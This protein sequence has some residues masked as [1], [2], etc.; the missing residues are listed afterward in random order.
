MGNFT[1]IGDLGRI[2]IS[3]LV[4]FIIVY[5]GW[6]HTALVFSII[7][8]ALLLVLSKIMSSSKNSID[9]KQERS[10]NVPIIKFLQTKA[11]IFANMVNLLDTI[12]S[13]SLFIF[14]PFLLI[15]RGISPSVLGAFAAAYF[16]GNF[17]GKTILGGFVD[18]FGNATVFVLSEI[19]MAAFI[20][21]LANSSNIVVIVVSSIVLGIFTKGTVPVVKTMVSESVSHHNDFEKAFGINSVVAGIA[22]TITPATLGF[23]SNRYG[24]INAFNTEAVFALLA[25]IPAILYQITRRKPL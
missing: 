25:T 4:T 3:S 21:I 1:A 14:L 15:K 23:I 8:V 22:I 16:V 11:F 9:G 18:K 19:L 24:I 10:K 20:F 13:S 5:L 7:G 12:A 17:L 6:R 2:G